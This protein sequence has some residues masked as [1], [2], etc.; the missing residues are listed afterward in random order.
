MKLTSFNEIKIPIAL[1]IVINT[2]LIVVYALYDVHNALDLFLALAALFVL[3]AIS[4][5]YHL[6]LCLCTRKK[7]IKNA[8][9]VPLYLL[10]AAF[11]LFVAI[12]FPRGFEL[13]NQKSKLVSY[14]KKYTMEMNIKHNR[15]IVSIYD[16]Q[17]K[18]L[19]SDDR[20]KFS[21]LLNVYWIWDQKDRLWL[22]NSDDA[23]VYYWVN[24]PKGWKKV[25]W[26]YESDNISHRFQ[27]PKALYPKYD[28]D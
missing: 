2:I 22:Y 9:K 1:L 7:S 19:Y 16:D 21:G 24:T 4:T 23:F 27:P 8:F 26:G 18:K 25:C 17:G 20:S 13:P 11:F 5:V 12:F 10:P 6:V 3:L 14:D 28:S 15:W